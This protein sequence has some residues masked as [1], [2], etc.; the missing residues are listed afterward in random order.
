GLVVGTFP[1]NLDNMRLI[2][3]ELLTVLAKQ[4]KLRKLV[5][6]AAEDE[7]A[8]VYQI[9]FADMLGDRPTVKTEAPGSLAAS[10]VGLSEKEEG[11]VFHE[12]LM[13]K[14]SRLLHIDVA[15]GVVQLA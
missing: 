6:R 15:R 9:R 7:E 10:W 5:E 12:R 3:T 1:I 11:R 14:R 4:G 2:W 8:G 13:E